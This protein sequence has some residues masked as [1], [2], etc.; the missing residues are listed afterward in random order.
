MWIN[1]AVLT[2]ITF[3]SLLLIEHKKVFQCPS[4]HSRPTPVWPFMRDV[5]RSPVVM[6][7]ILWDSIWHVGLFWQM[8]SFSFS[9]SNFPL[10]SGTIL[11]TISF[12]CLSPVLS[13]LS[14]SYPYLF[15]PA[16][17]TCLD[18]RLPPNIPLSS[19]LPFPISTT[20]LLSLMLLSLSPLVS[21]P[22]SSSSE[23][24]HHFVLVKPGTSAW[25]HSAP[26]I[27][28]WEVIP[29]EPNVRLKKSTIKHKQFTL[30]AN[31]LDFT[32]ILLKGWTARLISDSTGSGGS[33]LA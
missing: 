29:L 23:A 26:L 16:L 30:T 17:S 32:F 19:F 21:L 4:Q 24:V 11:C 6:I 3:K 31:I 18:P 15:S 8:S 13:Y 9:A 14:L 5:I 7:I 10:S 12:F 1:S 2:Q 33:G 20:F 28:S 22:P 27:G 25:L